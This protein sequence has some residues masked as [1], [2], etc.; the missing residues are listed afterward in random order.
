MPFPTSSTL[1]CSLL[2]GDVALVAST[3]GVVS[4]TVAQD[5]YS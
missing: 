3:V 1:A 5:Y 2:Y 4:P